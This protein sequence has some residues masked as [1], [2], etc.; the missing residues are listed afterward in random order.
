M[1]NVF[2]TGATGNV[3]FE[4]IKSLLKLN[5]KLNIFAGIHNPIADEEKLKGLKINLVDFDFTNIKSYDKCL[6]GQS[7][8]F[9][10]RPPQLSQVNK[11]FKPFIDSAKRSGIGYI[12]FLSVQGVEKNNLIPHHKIEKLIVKSEIPYTFLRPA[13]FMQNFTTT[14]RNDLLKK[15]RIFLPAG[16]SKFTLID[17]RDAGSVA[18]IVLTNNRGHVNKAYELTCNQKLNFY[19]MADKLSTGLEVS[20][21]YESPS[22]L[23]FYIIKR[24]EKMPSMLILVMMMLHY[25]PR[26]QKEPVTTNWVEKITGLHPISFDQF[27]IDNKTLLI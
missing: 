27:I 3:G 19:T 5:H 13:Y 26:F 24:K 12:V 14:L 8:L 23:K 18:A 4:V 2:I 15:K 16:H 6:S 22:L 20:I 7:I 17:V 25:L 10:I 9:L 1:K 21:K 11:Y